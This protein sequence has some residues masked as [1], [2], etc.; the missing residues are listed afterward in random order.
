MKKN[1]AIKGKILKKLGKNVSHFRDKLNITQEKLAEKIDAERSY[2]AA[3]E[4]GSKSP[5]V[6]CL[7]QLAKALNIPLKELLDINIEKQ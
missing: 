5:S 4:G 1:E 3:I 6:Y 2:I 7:Y